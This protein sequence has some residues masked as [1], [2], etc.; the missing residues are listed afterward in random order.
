MSKAIIQG[1]KRWFPIDFLLA[2]A[3][4]CGRVR[5]AKLA[6]GFTD[7]R[8]NFQLDL[9]CRWNVL[10][11]SPFGRKFGLT[12]CPSGVN[13]RN[14]Y[15]PR[16]NCVRA[17]CDQHRRSVGPTSEGNHRFSLKSRL[18]SFSRDAFTRSDAPTRRLAAPPVPVKPSGPHFQ[19]VDLGQAI[20]QAIYQS[21]SHLRSPS[22]SPGIHMLPTAKRSQHRHLAAEVS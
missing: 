2:L 5:T 20:Q 9:S 13:S 22:G 15:S 16:A 18:E 11:E 19:A 17:N 21:A 7:C 1:R 3:E 8:L 6:V 12:C 14:G 4:N 10:V